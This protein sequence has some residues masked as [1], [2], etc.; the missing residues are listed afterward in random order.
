MNETDNDGLDVRLGVTESGALT[1]ATLTGT[2]PLEWEDSLPSTRDGVL[3]VVAIIIGLWYSVV[4][5]GAMSAGFAYLHKG[6]EGSYRLVQ[7]LLWTVGIGIGVAFGVCLSRSLQK[8]VGIVCSLALSGI[9][10]SLLLLHPSDDDLELSLFEHSFSVTQILIGIAVAT[11]FFGLVGTFVG[12]A[13]RADAVFHESLLG[14]R[15]GHWWWL[16]IALYAWVV[17]VPT[18]AYYFWLERVS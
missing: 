14:I 15:H 3:P 5:A 6:S 18:A 12:R 11:L 9:L 1:T 10:M 17:I 2:A 8:T 4:A 13:V 16:W 7:T